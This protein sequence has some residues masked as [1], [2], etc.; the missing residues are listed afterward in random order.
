MIGAYVCDRPLGGAG[1]TTSKFF[2]APEI[3]VAATALAAAMEF[4]A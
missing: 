4:A 1:F 3:A 2:M